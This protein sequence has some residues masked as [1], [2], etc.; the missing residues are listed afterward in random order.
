MN[1]LHLFAINLS[2][3]KV[4]QMFVVMENYSSWILSPGL[5]C[6]GGKISWTASSRPWGRW[7]WIC[8]SPRGTWPPSWRWPW[9]PGTRGHGTGQTL[10]PHCHRD[11]EVAWCRGREGAVSLENSPRSRLVATISQGSR[12]TL[13]SHC[14]HSSSS[15]STLSLLSMCTLKFFECYCPIVT[16]KCSDAASED[17]TPLS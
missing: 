7:V 3:M 1:V 11:W 9:V 14:S 15:H 17:V 8:T 4:L 13:R 2:L 5:C 16:D 12:T 10:R 6:S